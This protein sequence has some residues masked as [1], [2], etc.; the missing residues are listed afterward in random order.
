MNT[1][2]N[3]NVKMVTDFA[4]EEY[5]KFAKKM[6]TDVGGENEIYIGLPKNSEVE[7][8]EWKDEIY[9]DVKN[10]KGVITGS[11]PCSVVIAMYR[12]LKECGCRFI[13]PGKDGDYIPETTLLDKTVFVNEKAT[14][15]MRCMVIEG[16]DSVENVY[17]MIDFCPKIG[18]NTYRFQ[19][20]T[21]INFLKRWY[22]HTKNPYR[23][24]EN[25]EEKELQEKERMLKKAVIT[26]G[27][28]LYTMGHGWTAYPVGLF[29]DGWGKL[30]DE[31][32]EAAKPY[33]A[34]YNGKRELINGK[35]FLSNLCY[36]N[37]EVQEKMADYMVQYC[38]EYP[39]ASIVSF[40]LADN[41][42]TLCECENCAGTR[43]SDHIINMVNVIDERL[44]KE[45]INIKVTFGAYLD[46]LW[47]PLKYKLK[48][49]E[50]HSVGFFPI[51]HVYHEPLPTENIPAEEPFPYVLNKLSQTENTAK[52]LSFFK[53]WQKQIDTDYFIGEYH[54]M[55]DHYLDIG[56]QK[57][58]KVLSEDIK[59]HSKLGITGMIMF[60]P[61][62]CAVP[63]AIGLYTYGHTLWD[64]TTS[65]EALSEDYFSYAY[66]SNWEQVL[67]Y[68]QTLSDTYDMKI[69][70]GGRDYTALDCIPVLEKCIEMVDAFEAKHEAI[71]DE[72]T[73]L[74]KT[75]WSD[76]ALHNKY[77]KR[78]L[79]AVLVG[80][81]GEEEKGQELINDLCNWLW[82]IEDEVQERWDIALH[83]GHLP[84][85]YDRLMKIKE[86]EAN[87]VKASDIVGGAGD[88]G[89]QA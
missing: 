53:A 16:Y 1:F 23:E 14:T 57:I 8:D 58:A 60:Q 74:T 39:E 50:R 71:K 6:F 46:S 68:L 83:T 81:N 44:I 5:E 54:Y 27:M 17:D 63:N 76:L 41:I 52:N 19:F 11:N 29:P 30:P 82:T 28:R 15:G 18:L 31:A 49:P 84:V 40:S 55:W 89:V 36:S 75:S 72:S 47:A 4:N 21:S 87:N 48:Y 43:L 34:L 12:F 80:L 56:Y 37:P 20:L 33:L 67:D 62:R 22:K 79:S 26:R 32:V 77:V 42:N 86:D 3:E 38:K 10:G 78:Y 35:P 69:K 45:G 73:P 85:W 64:K 51:S 2:S 70:P 61:Q 7:L 13:R 24:D 66:G 65:F 88:E 59:S 9:I 25:V